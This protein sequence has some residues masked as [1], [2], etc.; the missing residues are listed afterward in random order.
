MK[1]TLINY[2]GSKIKLQTASP[3]ECD[4]AFLQEAVTEPHQP[5]KSRDFGQRTLRK[6]AVDASFRRP[7]APGSG[8][9][10]R[11]RTQPR[12]EGKAGPSVG[13]RVRRRRAQEGPA[14]GDKVERAGENKNAKEREAGVR[15]SGR[16]HYD[17]CVD[18]QRSAPVR[19]RLSL[20]QIPPRSSPE[21][22]RVPRPR[23][24]APSSA[25]APKAP[26]A[27]AS[28]AKSMRRADDEAEAAK[29]RFK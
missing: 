18:Q 21:S 20:G 5:P 3:Q 2:T 6:K 19:A 10:I 22:P 11:S 17:P 4:L 29:D 9:K 13:D 26:R 1:Q 25:M 27:T 16:F 15:L 12:H 28:K 14:E 7:R 8:A 24:G 23:N